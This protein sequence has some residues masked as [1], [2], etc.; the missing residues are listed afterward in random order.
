MKDY[1]AWKLA[2]PPDCEEEDMYVSCEIEDDYGPCA[3]EGKVVAQ[4]AADR[5]LWSCPIC[6]WD[7]EERWADHD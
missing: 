2:S 6:D 1:D 7:H 5:Y 4:V 3:F